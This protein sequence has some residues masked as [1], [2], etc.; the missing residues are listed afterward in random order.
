VP[1]YALGE[2]VPTIDETAF[3]HPDAVIIGN[4]TIGA[5]SSVWPCAVLRGDGGEIRVGART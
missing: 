5:Q 4:V 2:L 3:V 1:I